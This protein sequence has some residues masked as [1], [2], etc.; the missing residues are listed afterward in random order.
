MRPV[1]FVALVIALFVAPLF[2]RVYAASLKIDPKNATVVAGQEF[3]VDVIVDPGTDQITSTD[4]YLMFD[5]NYLSATSVTAGTYFPTVLNDISAGRV[6]IAGLVDNPTDYKTGVGTIAKVTMKALA[7]GTVSL[8][9]RCG[10]TFAD[11]SKI[12][13][14]DANSS[15]IIVCS[16][17]DESSITVGNGVS[18]ITATPS[19]SSLPTTGGSTTATS[20]STTTTSAARPDTLP[21]SG[22]IDNLLR[23]L[24]PGIGFVMVG[25]VLHLVL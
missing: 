13:K 1:L 5:K 2:T 11:T 16:T 18:S 15:N 10:S 25:I 24:V 6:Y 17:N 8:S 20:S 3:T 19:L 22:V 7:N 12:I 9:Y 14:N 4:V 23:A 21:Q